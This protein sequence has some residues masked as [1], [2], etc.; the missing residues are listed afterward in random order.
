M[1]FTPSENPITHPER[2]S[3]TELRP[4]RF[5]CQKVLPLVYDDTLSYY[6]LLCKVVDYLNKTM[7]DVDHMNTDMDT[8]YSNFQQFQ[9]GTIRIY[10]ELV[11]YVNAYFENLDVQEEINNKLDDMVTSGELVTILQPSIADEV[12]SWLDEHITPTTPAIDNTLS[13][14]GA[15]ADAK[16][17]GDAITN[18]RAL[19]VKNARIFTGTSANDISDSTWYFCD[20]SSVSNC[21]NNTQAFYILTLPIGPDS[22]R[23]Q[24]AFNWSTGL[25]SYRRRL[26]DL[27]WEAWRDSIPFDVIKNYGISSATSCN[28]LTENGWYFCDGAS[29]SDLPNNTQAF[30][31]L[32]LTFISGVTTRLQYAINWTTGVPYFRRCNNNNV[33]TA[34]TSNLPFDAMKNY[35]IYTGSSANDIS[36]NGWFFCDGTS[37][38]DCPNNTQ[39]FYILNLMIQ[40]GGTTRLQYA[41]NWTTGESNYRRR[42][43][44]GTWQAWVV[45]LAFK[46]LKNHSI[47][48]GNDANNLDQ[49]GWYFCD[50]NAVAHCPNSTQSFY[51][52]N[53]MIQEG[54]T[55]RLQYAI[56]WTTGDPSYRRMLYDGTWVEWKGKNELSIGT[57]YV[58]FGDSIFWGAIWTD[59]ESYRADIK[60]QIPTRIAKA[61]GFYENFI[62][63]AVGGTGYCN[64]G[65]S[66]TITQKALNYDFSNVEIATF[67][68]GVNDK[69]TYQLGT[70]NSVAGDGTICGA[71]KQ[72]IN[73]LSTNY[74]R[75][76][77]VFT[78]PTPSGHLSDAWNGTLDGGWSLNDFIRE[79]GTICENE[80]VSF[81]DYKDSVYCKQW[82]L[83]SGGTGGG[84]SANYSHFKIESDSARFGDYVAGKISAHFHGNH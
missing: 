83:F 56:N 60:N 46:T 5:W 27:T 33:W 28:N 18:L 69:P 48:S 63:E 75:T 74:P 6:E 42:N 34:W 11:A 66:T 84:S 68:G 82:D 55:T 36:T 50:G 23:F 38:A 54:G 49:N 47:Y 19:S 35:A 43:F 37:V 8:L 12:A 32:N 4:F 20:G 51:I 25:Y 58:A 61:I 59:T 41:I 29:I 44:D 9:E 24:L 13:V 7:E 40:E 62:N 14:A 2:E 1:S 76:Q 79:V 67:S 78:Q 17:A 64:P 10:N 81:V 80:H 57:K 71:I 53:L 30:Y 15:A 72:I 31:V 16:A 73:Y 45:P 39:A 3:Y 77:I 26:F 22:T 21:P 65:N 70:A 52:L